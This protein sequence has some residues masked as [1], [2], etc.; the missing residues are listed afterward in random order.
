MST[1]APVVSMLSTSFVAVPAFSLVEPAITSAPTAGEM[2]MSTNVCS[3]V[4][5]SQ[6]TKMMRDPA[7]RAPVNAPRTNWV[8]PLADTPM[9]T[10]LLVGAK[11]VMARTPSS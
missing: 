5:G 9:T 8:M 6:V 7:L 4:A 11:R 10:S 1:I 2:V 3:S